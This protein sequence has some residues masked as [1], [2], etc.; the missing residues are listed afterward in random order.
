MA[1]F[2][3]RAAVHPQRVCSL[4]LSAASPSPSLGTTRAMWESVS[5]AMSR[6]PGPLVKVWNVPHRRMKGRH[7][8]FD[9]GAGV[10]VRRR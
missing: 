1:R 8:V 5:D 4:M 10:L 9:K 3:P 6:Q 7:E 2:V